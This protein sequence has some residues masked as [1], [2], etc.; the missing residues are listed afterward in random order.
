MLIPSELRK[1][2]SA[3]LAR[4]AL[5]L[6]TRFTG[7]EYVALNYPGQPFVL[8]DYPTSASNSPRWT[9]PHPELERL[10]ASHH[11]AYRR[12]LA[13]IA[14]YQRDFDRIDV[15]QRNPREPHWVNGF[16]Y[17]PDSGAIYAFL[18]SRDP[19]HYLEVGSGNSTKFAHRARRDGDLRTQ[20]ISIDPDPREEIDEICDEVMRSGLETMDL[21]I[22]DEL[23][24]GD[25]LF[26]DGSH[27]VFMNSDV[28]V[29]FLEVLPRLHPG[30]LVGVHDVFLPYDYP[31]EFA[32]RYYSEQYMLAALLMADSPKLV[33]VL[34][35]WYA[36]RNPELRKMLD[37][38]WSDPKLA[39]IKTHGSAFW[40]EICPKG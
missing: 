25:V 10:I 9:T 1:R 7:R 26:F 2:A 32:N 4:R 17:G 31:A 29:F 27:R 18:R 34:A 38:T 13:T 12:S 11:S 20:I 8:L 21:S 37:E 36:S 5:R 24:E 30:V 39:G 6:A 35:C 40:L 15:E 19:E 22:I 28:T 16:L 23:G 3:W 14:G 33:P